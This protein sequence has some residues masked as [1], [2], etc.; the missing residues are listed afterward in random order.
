MDYIASNAFTLLCM[1]LM[2]AFETR[3]TRTCV[4]S[5]LRSSTGAGGRLVVVNTLPRLADKRL[6][7]FLS[8]LFWLVRTA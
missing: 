4:A 7:N 2:S 6:A 1:V 8:L 3:T 5:Q